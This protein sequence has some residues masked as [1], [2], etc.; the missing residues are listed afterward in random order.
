MD[1]DTQAYA[2]NRVSFELLSS[3][4]IFRR[5]SRPPFCRR[6][7]PPLTPLNQG[8]DKLPKRDQEALFRTI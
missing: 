6:S 7:S 1:T 8:I 5:L 2:P 4:T 3:A